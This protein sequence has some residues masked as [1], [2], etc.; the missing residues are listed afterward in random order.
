M[1]AAVRHVTDRSRGRGSR[2]DSVTATERTVLHATERAT[3]Y[4]S[5]VAR[6]DDL[7]VADMER[8]LYERRT[9]VKQLAMRRTVFVFPRDLLP[10][11]WGSASARVA[12]Q[13]STRLAKEIEMHG[14]AA[15]GA[16]W[17]DEAGA[18]VLDLL[19]DG[20][21]RGAQVIRKTLPVHDGRMHLAAGK[22]YSAN[23]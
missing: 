4:L 22:P 6:V 21:E 1:T 15:A 5:L 10:P 8:E 13:L 14:V 9:L 7:T 2:G 18:A 3:V 23:V 19:A 12:V 17:L 11:A 16:A 20:S